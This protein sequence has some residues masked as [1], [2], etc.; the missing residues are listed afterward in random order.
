[1]TFCAFSSKVN[2]YANLSKV[3]RLYPEKISQAL[4]FF[5]VSHTHAKIRLFHQLP[6]KAPSGMDSHVWMAY[7]AAV[8]QVGVSRARKPYPD[9]WFWQKYNVA[10]SPLKMIVKTRNL[11]F[12]STIY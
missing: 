9:H 4:S 2:V 5:M 8:L 12:E 1:M 7:R 3:E 11:S 6:K 10:D